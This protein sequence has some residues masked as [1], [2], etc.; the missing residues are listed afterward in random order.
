MIQ[1]PRWISIQ[2]SR[3]EQRKKQVVGPPKWTVQQLTLPH[4]DGEER[5]TVMIL[6]ISDIHLK[7]RVSAQQSTPHHDSLAEDHPHDPLRGKPAPDNHQTTATAHCRQ[8]ESLG[9]AVRLHSRK[10]V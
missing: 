2:K 4:Y 10:S 6:L 1:Q 7:L 8:G 3:K 9:C 5:F